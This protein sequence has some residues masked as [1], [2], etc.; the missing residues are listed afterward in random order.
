MTRRTGD[1]SDLRSGWLSTGM[2]C[3]ISDVEHLVGGTK[4]HVCPV[5][6]GLAEDP[7]P[8]VEH[9]DSVPAVDVWRL[10]GCTDRPIFG[11]ERDAHH[12]REVEQSVQVLV[13]RAVASAVDADRQPGQASAHQDSERL[14]RRERRPRSDDLGRRQMRGPHPVGVYDCR[15]LP[16]S[17][18]STA[19]DRVRQGTRRSVRA[20]A[21]D[22]AGI[23]GDRYGRPECV[24]AH[25]W[26]GGAVGDA[27]SRTVDPLAARCRLGC[28]FAQC[29]VVSAC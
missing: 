15:L 20:V 22:A 27:A 11:A 3:R 23:R 12:V 17:A 13:W 10:P 14:C 4:H 16:S 28:R 8:P 7:C 1:P 5:L 26:L 18:P 21:V 29:R 6:S 25:S 19:T 2:P 24:S 9:V